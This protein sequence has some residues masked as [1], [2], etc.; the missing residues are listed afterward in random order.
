MSTRRYRYMRPAQRDAKAEQ[1]PRIQ[2]DD[3]R[4][5][6]FLDLRGA[7]GPSLRFVPVRGKIAW[8]QVD[9]DTGRVL[10]RGA[11]KQLLHGVADEL[12]R[13]Q[14]PSNYD[15]RDDVPMPEVP[16]TGADETDAAQAWNR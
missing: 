11:I 15:W 10:A 14:A 5:E 6:V 8:T 1:H 9:A 16:D 12:P 7:G 3:F 4:T 2:A 13:M